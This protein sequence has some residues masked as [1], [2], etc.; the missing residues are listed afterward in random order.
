MCWDARP[1][2]FLG[3]IWFLRPDVFE[4]AEECRETPDLPDLADFYET[5][6]LLDL[7]ET[8]EFEEA[9]NL[10]FEEMFLLFR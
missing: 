4:K 1:I 3:L 8:A 10:A 6:L 2:P 7:A 9:R 5:A